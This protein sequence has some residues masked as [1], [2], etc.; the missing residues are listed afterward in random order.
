MSTAAL[1][2]DAVAALRRAGFQKEA[3]VV[4]RSRCARYPWVDRAAL[5]D[6]DGAVQRG[7]EALRRVVSLAIHAGLA[8]M[9]EPTAELERRL[10]AARSAVEAAL[11]AVDA[12]A[13]P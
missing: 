2:V 13:L 1:I 12:E 11:Q 9:A 5:R 7:H 3:S 6:T 8:D 4:D 10:F